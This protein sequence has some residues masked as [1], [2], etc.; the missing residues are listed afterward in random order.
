[1][2]DVGGVA[3]S[4]GSACEV[5][6]TEVD[7]GQNWSRKSAQC[8]RSS[9]CLTAG[10]LYCESGEDYAET[11]APGPHA[12]F[13]G[14][15][16]TCRHQGRSDV[17]DSG[18]AVPRINSISRLTHRGYLAREYHGTSERPDRAT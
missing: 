4:A 12:G 16:G 11:T 7:I 14:E 10:T 5:P 1:V 13:Q 6:A 2:A 3:G 15:G 18:L 8:D 9:F 17:R